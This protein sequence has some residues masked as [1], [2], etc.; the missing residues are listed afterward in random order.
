M[1]RPNGL[2]KSVRLSNHLAD[3]VC[4]LSAYNDKV[5][6]SIGSSITSTEK[7]LAVPD[8][9]AGP[10]LVRADLLPDHTLSTLYRKK[11][12]VNLATASNHRLKTLG[13]AILTVNIEGYICR[14]PFV[15]VQALAA[16]VIHG[17]TCIDL[18][19]NDINIRQ[20]TFRL[21][22]GTT[23]PIRRRA[24]GLPTPVRSKEPTQVTPRGRPKEDLVRVA[25]SIVLPPGPETNVKFV[26]ETTGTVLLE[27]V[28]KLYTKRQISL[29]KGNAYIRKNVPYPVRV[30]KF[31]TKERRLTKNHV[32]G[33]V[34]RAPRSILTIDMPGVQAP[35]D[36][37]RVSNTVVTPAEPH[38][39][40][41]G[42]AW[43]LR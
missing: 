37:P 9:G 35:G 16:D 20:Q 24:A 29:S 25:Q 5:N 31:S 7:V 27:P 2:P 6:A 33:F 11:R 8:T 18:D 15:V 23:V 10:N 28:A 3:P 39:M 22:D 26:S 4:Y 36:P 42:K 17:A 21:I 43:P 30:A 34:T 13:I 14:Q 32:L 41:A 1:K 12:I 40:R 19:G 38:P